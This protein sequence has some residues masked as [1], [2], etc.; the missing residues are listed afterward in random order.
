MPNKRIEPLRPVVGVLKHDVVTVVQIV[1]DSRNTTGQRATGLG[2]TVIHSLIGHISKGVLS[3]P[4]K[5]SHLFTL[6]IKPSCI[7]ISAVEW[8]ISKHFHHSVRYI[9]RHSSLPFFEGRCYPPL[10]L[11]GFRDCYS[12]GS[13]FAAIVHA[14]CGDS[15][16]GIGLVRRDKQLTSPV[17]HR[18]NRVSTAYRPN[19]ALG[20]K[21]GSRYNGGVLSVLTQLQGVRAVDSDRGNGLRRGSEDKGVGKGRSAEG[22]PHM[23]EVVPVQTLAVVVLGELHQV[24]EHHEPLTVNQR[25]NTSGESAEVINENTVSHELGLTHVEC[26]SQHLHINDGIKGSIQDKELVVLLGKVHN[27]HSIILAGHEL[28][29]IADCLDVGHDFLGGSGRRFGDNNGIHTALGGSI[30]DKLL[31]AQEFIELRTSVHTVHDSCN[32]VSNPFRGKERLPQLLLRNGS[33]VEV[34][35]VH[36]VEHSGHIRD[37]P[38]EH[39]FLS[40]DRVKGVGLGDVDENLLDG[41]AVFHHPFFEHLQGVL[42]RFAG[43]DNT[44]DTVHQ[45]IQKLVLRSLELHHR[46]TNVTDII[47]RSY[48]NPLAVGVTRIAT[49]GVQNVHAVTCQRGRIGFYWHFVHSFLNKESNEIL[50]GSGS[51]SGSAAGSPASS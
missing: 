47:L 15:Q 12:L 19:H 42:V 34:L 16:L 37:F 44:G 11:L 21:V 25:G 46:I 36:F 50:S 8:N 3:F 32:E 24:I 2:H 23:V 40:Q 39:R 14:G 35:E 51:G 27:A 43:D 18:L 38:F 13:L 4:S 17:N 49:N 28:Q 20:R 7:S 30:L 22:F 33:L 26:G 29:L 1:C 9:V 5:E 10:V 41:L 6:T 31:H 45:G 48:R